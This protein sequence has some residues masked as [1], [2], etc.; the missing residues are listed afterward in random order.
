M[1]TEWTD[2]V[3]T[4]RPARAGDA[5][6][7]YEAVRESVPELSRWMSWC[8]EN[9]SMAEAEAFLA[10]LPEAW[11]VGAEYGFFSF[12]AP[13]GAL[14]GGVGLNY[15]N[16]DYMMC[17]L[18]Y[19]VRTSRAGRGVASRATRLAARFA[20][21]ELGMQRVEIVAA[22]GNHASRRAAEKAG[23]AREGTL[24]KRLLIRG[25]PHDAVLFSLVAEDLSDAT[26][27]AE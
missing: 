27:Q 3:V 14:L 4:I 21:A 6:L 2:G 23:A 13:T 26:A 11:R 15:V 22:V 18:G 24:R 25:Q 10:A 8:H 20:F 17:N 12:D 9:Y 7:M 19:W 1:K 5:G 16:R